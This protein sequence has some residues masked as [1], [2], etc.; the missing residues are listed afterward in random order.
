MLGDVSQAWQT[1]LGGGAVYKQTVYT[2]SSVGKQTE[3]YVEY[4]PNSES[5]PVVVNGASVYGKRTL[6][7]A[8]DYM[9]KNHLRPLI[10]IN[11]DFFS[12]KGAFAV[13]MVD[14][15]R[16]TAEIAAFADSKST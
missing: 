1:D 14:S 15:P 5:V 11:A 7:S 8:A 13:T 9:E 3:N 16:F 2:S 10:G 12:T 4:T 6:T